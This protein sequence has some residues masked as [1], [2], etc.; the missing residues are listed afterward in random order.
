IFLQKTRSQL[1]VQNNTQ[2]LEELLKQMNINN[3]FQNNILNSINKDTI[4]DFRGFK[5]KAEVASKFLELERM[6]KQ[7]FPGREIII[8]SGMDGQHMPNSAHYRG[9]ALDFVVEPL[10]VEESKIVE[11]LAEK[12][13]FKVYNEYIYDSPYKTGPHMHIQL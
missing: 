7:H 12:A 5:M 8:T 1:P 2:S 4:I 3:N 13:G 6:I 9:E 10:T 11:K